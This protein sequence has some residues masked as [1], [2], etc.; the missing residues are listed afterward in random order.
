MDHIY[1]DHIYMDHILFEE[2]CL[3]ILRHPGDV[4]VSKE[5]LSNRIYVATVSDGQRASAT[6]KRVP[7]SVPYLDLLGFKNLTFFQKSM[8]L[9]R[10]FF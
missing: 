6:L 2:V 9:T 5:G 4:R 7:E 10:P 3:C 1:M 8:V